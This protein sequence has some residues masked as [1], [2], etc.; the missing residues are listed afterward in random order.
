MNPEVG[1]TSAEESYDEILGEL[2]GSDLIFLCAGLG[3]GTVWCY[4]DGSVRDSVSV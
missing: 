2:N 1:R 4:T 3:G